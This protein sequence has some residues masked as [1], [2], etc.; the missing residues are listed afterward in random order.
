MDIV[1]RNA[2]YRSLNEYSSLPSDISAHKPAVLA[3]WI[4]NLFK[5]LG[6]I[7]FFSAW[8]ATVYSD[9]NRFLVVHCTGLCLVT[10]AWLP[11]LSSKLEI[12]DEMSL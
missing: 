3:S 6:A 9:V 7:E 12:S 10:I 11:N 4:T 1:A 2:A 5:T 8:C